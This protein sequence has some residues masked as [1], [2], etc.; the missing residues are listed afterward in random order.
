MEFTKEELANE[1]WRDVVGYG[2]M[3]QVSSLG[4]IKN[5]VLNKM[6]KISRAGRYER[7]GLFAIE[8]KK[9]I[10]HLV[11]RLVAIAFIPN[12]DNFPI[13]NHKDEDRYNN[14]V[15][16][17]EWCDNFYN[18][19]YGTKNARMLKTR[20]SNK[21]KTAPRKV[22]QYDMDGNLLEIYESLHEADR[23]TNADYRA[24]FM[25]CR[26]RIHHHKGYIWKYAE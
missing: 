13:I 10:T 6:L 23:Q 19:S 11:H 8:K 20:I 3:Y 12:P 25:C 7:I 1:E 22:A 17:L 26:G 18:N 21:A 5:V 14:R 24:I 9:Q 15:E 16:N 4:R 2:G